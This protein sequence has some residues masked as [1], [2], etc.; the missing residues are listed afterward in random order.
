MIE[1]I[2]TLA[3]SVHSN[4]GIYALLLG[5]GLSRPAGIPTGWDVVLNLVRKV[6]ALAGEDCEPD[7][8]AW[9]QA[10]YGEEPDY[11]KLLNH[12]AKSPPERQQLLRS[13]FE[14][15]DDEREQ[16]LKL[17]TV[18][19][20]AIAD[21]VS[22]GYVRVIITTNFD[23]LMEQ[24]LDDVGVTPTVISSADQMSGALPLTHTRCT[25]IKIHGDY[26]DTRIKNTPEELAAYDP[27]MDSLLDRVFDEYGLIVCGW[28]A[29]WDP[30]LRAAIERCPSRRFTTFWAARGRVVEEAQ[31]LISHRRAELIEIEGADSFFQDL[32]EKVRALEHISLRH[33]LSKATAVATLKRYLPEDRHK[34]RAHDLVMDEGNR[35]QAELNETRFPLDGTNVTIDDI[36]NRM[37]EYLALSETL[38]A[39]VINGCY[40]GEQRHE[41]LWMKCIEMAA[42]HT[43]LGRGLGVYMELR[44][45]PALL[46]MY[47]GGVSA[48]AA[49]KYGNLAAVLTRV[50][51]HD[52]SLNRE[53]PLALLI[54]ADVVIHPN[55]AQHII[56]P[57]K[58]S[59]IPVSDY[60]FQVL[61]EPLRELMPRDAHYQESFDRF[62][63]L[64]TLTYVDLHEQLKA[65]QRWAIG[66]YL[67][68][69]VQ[70][71]EF[72]KT[73]LSQL[74]EEMDTVGG[75]SGLPA[76]LFGGS[77]MR[78]RAAREKFDEALPKLRRSVGMWT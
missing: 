1:P 52:I 62:E 7:P 44:D 76:G 10:K 23:R 39:L 63:Y 12:L 43:R 77:Q 34:I 20:R 33:P 51:G 75:W 29:Q 60:L 31:G 4:P 61:R 38:L 71:Y 56:A 40:W 55:V 28:S 78:L 22:K 70:H 9:Y 50:G 2:L 13:Y 36:A 14:P 74:Y 17:P 18:A 49:R 16:E 26:I 24:A 53:I 58:K 19:H 42:D 8:G 11:S 72:A 65:G 5:S 25:I 57:G 37:R 21:L 46:L 66:R 6:A 27:T 30:A 45:F 67:W 15:D 41:G 32:A 54:N 64:W 47:G 69:D 35:L 59:Y 48:V 68:R 3:I 73:V